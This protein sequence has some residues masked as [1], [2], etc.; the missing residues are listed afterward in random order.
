MT[1]MQVKYGLGNTASGTLNRKQT[2]GKYKQ[3]DLDD[4]DI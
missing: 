4:M 3:I 2:E 1:S